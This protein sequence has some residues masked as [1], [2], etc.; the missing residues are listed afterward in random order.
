[1]VPNAAHR[2][3]RPWIRTPFAAL[4]GQASKHFKFQG[5]G[6]KKGDNMTA[7]NVCP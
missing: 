2:G 7:A 1:V 3:C 6:H 4:R 5:G